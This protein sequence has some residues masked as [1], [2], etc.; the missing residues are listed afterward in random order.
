MLFWSL[1]EDDHIVEVGF[2][3]F[4]PVD[5]LVDDLDEMP[6]RLACSHRHAQP[7][8]EAGLDGKSRERDRVGVNRNL[9]ER[10]CKI[11]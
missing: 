4:H 9:V 5:H 7:L 3:A 8:E 10:P 2:D 6:G 1:I 11:E